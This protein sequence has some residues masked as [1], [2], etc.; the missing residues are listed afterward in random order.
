MFRKPYHFDIKEMSSY[1]EANYL[2]LCQI[3]PEILS[4]DDPKI[5]EYPQKK[6]TIDQGGHIPYE[7]VL[8]INEQCR[9][10]TMIDINFDINL[11][12]GYISAISNNNF[13][14]RL[15]H[16]AN[17]A[18][19]IS[20]NYSYNRLGSQNY[21][22]K[23]MHQPDEKVQQN[24]LLFEWLNLCLSDGMSKIDFCKDLGLSINIDTAK[25]NNSD[26][27]INFES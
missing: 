27:E 21:P 3:M 22:N 19:V 11:S 23:L 9:Y 24:K 20:F 14:V 10:T 5:D 1:C 7:M 12:K 16:D 8:V 17:M 25:K 6:I 18:E 2:L 26:F 15:Y 13:S 4:C